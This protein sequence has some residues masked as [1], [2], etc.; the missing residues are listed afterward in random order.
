MDIEY[1]ATF[2]NIDKNDMREKLKKAGAK[3]IR[4]EFL[5]KRVV[6]NLPKG[7]EIKGGWLRVRDEE[8]KITMSLKIVD[9][10]DIEDQ[11]EVSLQVNNFK[12][13]ELFL[14]AI[15]CKKKAYQESKRELWTLNNVEIFIDEWPFLEPFVEVEGES[16]EE[17]RKICQKIGLDYSKALFCAVGTLYSNKYGTPIDVINN[18]TPKIVF[19]GKNPFEKK[20]D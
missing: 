2:P 15:G 13:A 3:L 4:P 8:D 18:Q 10:E 20:G 5:Q 1:E 11:K 7:H 12:E 9:G 16:E 6:F 14:T 19:E 17:V